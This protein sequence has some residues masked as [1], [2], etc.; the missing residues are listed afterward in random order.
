MVKELSAHRKISSRIMSGIGIP[1]IH[2]PIPLNI[3]ISFMRIS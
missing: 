2:I 1:S 3:A